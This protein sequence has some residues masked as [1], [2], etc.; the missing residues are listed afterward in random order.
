[1]KILSGKHGL[2]EPHTMLKPY[3]QKLTKKEE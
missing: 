2:I 1:M 3:D